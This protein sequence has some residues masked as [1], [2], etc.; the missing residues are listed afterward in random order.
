MTEDQHPA[1]PEL[2]E[3]LVGMAAEAT[4]TE[5]EWWARRQAGTFRAASAA[6][7]QRLH[8]QTPADIPAEDKRE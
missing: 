4:E 2:S 8:D 1:D 3:P 7:Q 5:F 6:Y